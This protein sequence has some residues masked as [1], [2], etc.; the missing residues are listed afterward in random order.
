MNDLQTLV[1]QLSSG[2]VAQQAAAAEAL[3]QLGDGARPAAVA[4]IEAC[5]TTD[6]NVRQWCT[7]ALEELGPP[8]AGQIADL[9]RLARDPSR[10]V[11]YWAITLLGR[12]GDA[13][14]SAVATLADLVRNS[15]D[16]SLRER[17]AWAL[18]K[19]GAMAQPAIPALR[20]AAAS[21]QPRLSRLAKN[22]LDAIIGQ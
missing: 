5:A 17:A 7:A 6:E 22:A 9:I 18:G 3:A 1:T 12:A 20:E 10:D 2:N 21:N 13:A 15:A 14:P 19:M 4:L 11:A 16:S 8:S